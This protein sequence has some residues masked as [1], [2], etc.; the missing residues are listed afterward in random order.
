M[1]G[2]R[3][4]QL[5]GS[6]GR[7]DTVESRAALKALALQSTTAWGVRST[8]PSFFG[9]RAVFLAPSAVTAD[10][11]Q[12]TRFGHPGGGLGLALRELRLVATVAVVAVGVTEVA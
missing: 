6:R 1:G 11:T 10:K 12:G 8:F 9:C 3:G 7:S 2:L 4:G 5:L